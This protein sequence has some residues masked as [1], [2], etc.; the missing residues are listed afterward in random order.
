M[1]LVFFCVF[2]LF[3]VSG[4][5]VNLFIYYFFKWEG[6]WV[7]GKVE[8]GVGYYFRYMKYEKS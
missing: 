1:V 4:N 5:G 6:I 2:V 8:F 3:L 7:L